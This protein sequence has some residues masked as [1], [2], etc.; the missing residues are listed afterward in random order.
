MPA[1][2]RPARLVVVIGTG[3]EVGKTWVSSKLL[4]QA[5]KQQL[6]VAARKPAQSFDPHSTAPTDAELLAD[7]SGEAAEAVCP[8]HRWYPIA[9]APPIAAELL[10]RPPLLLD[11]LL[12]E[13]QWPAGTDLGLIET[14]GGLRSPIAHD[15]DCRDLVR[16]VAPDEVLLVADAGLGTINA[17]RLVIESLAF[18]KVTVF[19]NRFDAQSVLHARNREWLETRDGLRVIVDAGDF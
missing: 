2:D 12:A 8:P 10:N 13:I 4:L 14:A 11:A 18:A 6:R 19:L 5:R 9:M 16:R 15:G 7:A 3:T 17:V 1:A